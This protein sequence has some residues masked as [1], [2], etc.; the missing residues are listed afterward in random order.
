MPFGANAFF[1]GSVRGG[2]PCLEAAGELCLEETGDPR[3]G[4]GEG[5][6]ASKGETGMPMRG[7]HQLTTSF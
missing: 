6:Q 7:Q 2:E 5:F 4:G 1:P 3:L